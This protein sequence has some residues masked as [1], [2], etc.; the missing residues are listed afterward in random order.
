MKFGGCGIDSLQLGPS[1]GLLEASDGRLYGTTLLEGASGD[2]SISR[3]DLDGSNFTTIFSF[4]YIDGIE[5]ATEGPALTQGS[6][7]NLYGTTAGG[8]A[9]EGGIVFE[10]I[11]GLAPPLPSVR[12]IQPKSGPT[13]TKVR[14]TGNHLLGLSGV[15]FNGVSASFTPINVNYADAVVPGGATSGPI[16][17]TT[18]N[19][20]GTSKGSFEVQ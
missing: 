20:S 8:G 6:D 18:M 10:L 14:I 13:G 17:V 5:P 15:S 7:G 3:I 9:G 16:T 11:I 12:L 1:A 19:G 4:N 2:G